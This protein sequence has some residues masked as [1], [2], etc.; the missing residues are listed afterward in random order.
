MAQILLAD[1]ASFQDMHNL[2]Q[3]NFMHFYLDPVPH[4]M[5]DV[6]LQYL[7]YLSQLGISKSE[8]RLR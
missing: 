8:N 2:K 5:H 4:P 1:S 3:Q 7:N 6:A